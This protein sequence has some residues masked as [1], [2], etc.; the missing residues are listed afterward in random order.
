MSEGTTN[1]AVKTSPDTEIKLPKTST[2]PITKTGVTEG[3]NDSS[4]VIV[5]STSEPDET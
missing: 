2:P 4:N 5:T 1:R 3:N